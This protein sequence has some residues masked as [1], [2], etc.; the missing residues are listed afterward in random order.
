MRTILEGDPAPLAL[1]APLATETPGSAT[2]DL[3]VRYEGIRLLDTVTDDPPAAQGGLSGVVVTELGSVREFPPEALTGR[4]IRRIGLIG[5]APVDCELEVQLVEAASGK[6]VGPPAVLSLVADTEIATRWAE[7]GAQSAIG[8]PTNLRV[9][10]T[11]G[12]F[13]W[14]GTPRPL[15]RVAIFDPEYQGREMT[16]RGVVARARTHGRAGDA[17]GRHGVAG[18]AVRRVGRNGGVASPARERPVPDRRP[19]RP[20]PAVPA[21]STR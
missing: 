9:R 12:R 18:R 10:A 8:L 17:P 19:R 14:A 16:I 13:L 5:R 20:R 6:A 15:V 2:A 1:G 4:V 7:L 11:K 21:M 3:T